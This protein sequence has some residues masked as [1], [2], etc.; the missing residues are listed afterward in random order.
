MR[1]IS[2]L[3]AGCYQCGEDGGLRNQWGVNTGLADSTA[4]FSTTRA[5]R[6]DEDQ[7]LKIL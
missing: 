1:N 6:I 4:M 2:S 5:D 3:T 7:P